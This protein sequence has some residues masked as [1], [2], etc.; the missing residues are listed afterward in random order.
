M[1]P[2]AILCGGKGTRLAPLTD[3]I[4]KSLVDVCGKPF[5]VRQLELLKRNGYTDIVLLIGHMGEKI[6][7]VIG[8][9]SQYG[10]LVRYCEDGPTLRDRD[11]A[12]WQSYAWERA[13]A[14][15]VL[16]GDSY[17][18]CDYQQLER[19]FLA[20]GCEKLETMYHGVDYGL[21]A[22]RHDPSQ[23]KIALR[24]EMANPWEEIGSFKGLERVCDLF[25]DVS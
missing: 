1:L 14:L 19:G 9:G 21:R 7:A 3:K 15:F 24:V 20:S 16:Y 13:R 12:I 22:F 23:P 11:D 8:D 10:V 18:D 25:R 6:R 4:P 5:I 2:V 17:L